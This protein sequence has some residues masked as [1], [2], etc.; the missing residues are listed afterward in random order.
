[1][2]SCFRIFKQGDA[3]YLH[4]P[5]EIMDVVLKRLRMF[6]MRSQVI[7]DDLTQEMVQIGVA[8]ENATAALQQ[9][10]LNPAG[11]IDGISN[12]DGIFC[13]R[14]PGDVPRYTLFA[15]AS[16]AE[17][18]WSKLSAELMPCG[19]NSWRI[20]D[21]RAGQPEV[22]S[23][24]MEAFV[25][26]MA[27]LDLIDGVSFTKGCYPGQEIVARTHYLGKQK[28]RMYH[29]SCS[30]TAELQIG[31]KLIELDSDNNQGVG[32]IVN[33]AINAD[34]EQELLAVV[35]IKLA[36]QSKISSAEGNQCRTLTLPYS[37]D[38]E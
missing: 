8:G 14:L 13:M 6:V 30:Q 24:T 1:M 21:I 35:Q 2:Y 31:D 25:A 15:S 27:N 28:K 38:V 34:G 5:T 7:I 32:D 17:A 19:E 4:M 36:E 20:L 23:S 12:D 37:L 29:L 18:L 10:G 9:A 3:F 11:E 26:Q 22:F 16:Q 33:V